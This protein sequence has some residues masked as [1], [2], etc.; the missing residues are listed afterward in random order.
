M[1][2][3]I[4]PLSSHKIIALVTKSVFFNYIKNP[5]ILFNRERYSI[6]LHFDLFHGYNLLNR[7]TE[8]LD[9]EEKDSSL[10]KLIKKT[11]QENPNT[12][13]SAYSDNVAFTEGPKIEQFAPKTPNKPDF[14]EKSEI[15]SVISLKAETHN[16]PTTVEPFNGAATGSGGEIRDRLA[17]G[18]GS[19]PL[20]GT[21]VYMTSYSR[22]NENRTWEKGMQERKWLYQTP[23]DILIK[24]S[25]GAS[26]F[27][28][29]F[30]QPLITGSV[31]TFEHEEGDRML[32]FDKVIMQAGG[33]GFGKK[34]PLTL[35]K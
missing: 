8:L 17:G 1:F 30:G 7:A 2:H 29:K 11:S 12:I 18:K 9:G 3:K 13:V 27:G 28:N 20:S 35:I 33:I 14:F 31:L 15:N 5:K 26:D 24:A 34:E 10:F 16:F 21:A 6:N 32:G 23:M 25:N 22:L 19:L 4:I